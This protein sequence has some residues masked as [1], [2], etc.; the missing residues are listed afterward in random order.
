MSPYKRTTYLVI[1]L[2]SLLVRFLYI[3]E[4]EFNYLKMELFGDEITHFNWGCAVFE[5]QEDTIYPSF[6][7]P[8]Y[9]IFLSMF[10]NFPGDPTESAKHFQLM[11]GSIS[12]LLLTIAL[13]RFFGPFTGIISGIIL[14][15][16]PYLIYYDFQILI[17]STA[18]FGLSVLIYFLS[19]PHPSSAKIPAYSGFTLGLCSLLRSNFII[20]M[21][22]LIWYFG[23][24]RKTNALYFMLAYM[25][26]TTP[27]MI[28][29]TFYNG[30]FC[31][32]A[33]QGGINFWAGNHPNAD[34]LIPTS[35]AFPMSQEEYHP[36]MAMLPKK[37]WHMDNMWVVSNIVARIETDNSAL[38][39][40]SVSKYFYLHT[41][42]EIFDHKFQY[43]RII[44]KKFLNL[45][46]L[47]TIPNNTYPDHFFENFSP[48]LNILNQYP[49][50]LVLAFFLFPGFILS[51]INLPKSRILHILMCS[52]ALVLV[53]FFVNTRFKSQLLIFTVPM[54]VYG[55]FC[56]LNYLKMHQYKVLTRFLLIGFASLLLSF[57][58][59]LYH[60]SDDEKAMLALYHHRLA[61]IFIKHQ[62][63]IPARNELERA[64]KMNTLEKNI[65]LYTLAMT[66]LKEDTELARTLLNQSL[67]LEFHPQ[68]AKAMDE[69]PR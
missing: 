7:S 28:K 57:S 51:W 47:R 36:Y 13:S 30:S 56:G 34:G 19:L 44:L 6:R 48:F 9:G 66:Y 8:L 62:Q 68:V 31:G 61:Q 58:D 18:F 15:L 60:I 10:H 4:S 63:L 69:L 23:S 29:N 64:I 22:P 54:S 46:S 27:F 59:R 21:L 65:F 16:N 33:T 41:I 43:I 3:S 38:N 32:L 40:T 55:L 26:I 42:N 11:L 52:L 39:E 17:T 20:L 1:F 67:Q 12:V 24:H 50:K 2:F 5:G 37:I 45:F 35:P 53:L 49:L 14:A 25:A